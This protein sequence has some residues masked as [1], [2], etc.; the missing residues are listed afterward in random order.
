VKKQKLPPFG[1]HEALSKMKEAMVKQGQ[2]QEQDKERKMR[3]KIF[4][5]RAQYTVTEECDKTFEVIAF[6]EDDAEEVACEKVYEEENVEDDSVDI[7]ILEVREQGK[8][9][10]DQ[11]TLEMFPN[12][13]PECDK[14]K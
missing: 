11:K 3:G 2:D 12:A 6:D 14:S 9:S 7:C 8:G 10:D 13:V 4:K 5:V 1:D